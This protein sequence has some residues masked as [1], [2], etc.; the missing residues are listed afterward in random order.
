MAKSITAH[1]VK[2][3][4]VW[5]VIVSAIFLSGC[6]S[7]PKAGYILFENTTGIH[8]FDY[9]TNTFTKLEDNGIN[10]R[11]V[12]NDKENYTFLRSDGSGKYSI[13]L[14][15]MAGTEKPVTPPNINVM[16]YDYDL[17]HDGKWIVFVSGDDD[18]I[19]KVNVDGSGLKRLTSDGG[20]IT[21]IKNRYPQ[22]SPKGQIAYLKS[23][24]M[25]DYLYTMDDTGNNQLNLI[26][27]FSLYVL[28]APNWDLTGDR[29]TF[30]GRYGGPSGVDHIYIIDINNGKGAIQVQT[31]T[32]AMDKVASPIWGMA[33]SGSA[34]RGSTFD[35]STPTMA[36][37]SGLHWT[38]MIRCGIGCTL[39]DMTRRPV[40]SR[41]RSSYIIHGTIRIRG[42]CC[43]KILSGM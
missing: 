27:S 35:G 24:S 20:G 33:L 17:S 29:I 25:G 41:S 39:S 36:F 7:N 4:I 31:G 37:I 3:M 13:V 5:I 28:G 8:Y 26:P 14:S 11:W 12:P 34:S 42:Q 40:C 1:L 9:T 10:P 6:T 22:W 18:N 30:S 38:E 23:T 32:G 43:Q 16:T 2:V 15:D 21:K 19:Y